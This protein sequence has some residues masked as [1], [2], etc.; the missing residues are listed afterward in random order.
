[1]LIDYRGTD[2]DI[3]TYICSGKDRET[4]IQTVIQIDHR[5]TD[6]VT[7]IQ[8]IIQ[9]DYSG[10]DRDTEIQTVILRQITEIQTEI[11]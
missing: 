1:M 6:R 3:A 8:T 10:T 11:Q 4:E 7:D 2:R 9:I 5:Y